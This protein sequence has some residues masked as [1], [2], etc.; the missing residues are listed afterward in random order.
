MMKRH[1]ARLARQ[2]IKVTKL[3]DLTKHHGKGIKEIIASFGQFSHLLLVDNI[4]PLGLCENLSFSEL[5]FG[6]RI[7]G[8]LTCALKFGERRWKT[9]Y[10]SSLH[11]KS[12]GW[13]ACGGFGGEK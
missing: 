4:G 9:L 12:E 13:S 3:E 8:R 10:I 2:M 1:S 11:V 7:G 5:L 6:T